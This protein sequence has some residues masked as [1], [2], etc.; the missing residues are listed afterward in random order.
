ML[1]CFGN[2][3]IYRRIVLV[4]IWVII[5]IKN[6]CGG[7]GGIGGYVGVEEY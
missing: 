1:W 5:L 7:D 2:L 6:I 3:F 4:N